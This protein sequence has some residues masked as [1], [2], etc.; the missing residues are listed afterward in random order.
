MRYHL[1]NLRPGSLAVVLMWAWM[2]DPIAGKRKTDQG[3]YVCLFRVV[4]NTVLT[5]FYQEPQE[6]MMMDLIM[7]S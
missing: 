3:S 1:D 6:R 5:C 7:H 2:D 4:I